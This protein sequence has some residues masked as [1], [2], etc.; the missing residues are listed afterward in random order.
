MPAANTFCAMADRYVF[1]DEAGDFDFSEGVGASRYFIL[2]SVT[3]AD[4][5]VGDQLL[6][7]RRDLGW[8]GLL[9]DRPPHATYDPPHV[10]NEIMTNIATQPADRLRVDA[11]IIDK[12]KTP[13]SLRSRSTRRHGAC[14]SNIS[15]ARCCTIGIGCSWPARRSE[16]RRS[17]G[18]SI[19]T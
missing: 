6:A 7:L 2:T 16:P 3:V 17:D 13:P 5:S 10:R 11:T 4:C 12:A 8:R 9:L 18:S 14:T 15:H 19:R 1:A